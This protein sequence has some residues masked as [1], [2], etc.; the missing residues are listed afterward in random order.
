[1]EFY[2]GNVCHRIRVV[3]GYTHLGSYVRGDLHEGPAIGH[4]NGLMQ[5]LYQP[6]RKKLLYNPHLTVAE[7]QRLLAERV[8]PRFLYGAGLWR[9]RTQQEREGAIKPLAQ[10]ARTA[11]RPILG[12]TCEGLDQAEISAVLDQPLPIELIRGE[13]LRTWGELA[14]GADDFTWLA[15]REDGVWMRQAYDA[16]LLI[17]RATGLQ[18]PQPEDKTACR[19][20]AIQEQAALRNAIKAYLRRQVEGR[21][22]LGRQLRAA[23]DGWQRQQIP[24]QISLTDDFECNDCGATFSDARRLAVHRAKQHASWSAAR[25]ATFGT[26]CEVCTVEFWAPMRLQEHLRR[27]TRCLAAYAASDLATTAEASRVRDKADFAWRP[28]TVAAGP[29][30]WWATLRPAL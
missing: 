5:A 10:V 16:S 11:V 24:L 25:Q 9:L 15:L 1:M 30:P 19:S 23:R 28:A 13:Q 14:R 8:F 6:L 20:F 3:P 21:A 22:E 2:T 12:F 7:K 27:S 26:R 17:L 29:R 18:L 4:R